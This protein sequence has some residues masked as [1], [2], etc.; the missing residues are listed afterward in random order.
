MQAI[1]PAMF[2]YRR[3]LAGMAAAMTKTRPSTGT[4]LKALLTTSG[5][6]QPVVQGI[7]GPEAVS[8]RRW[9]RRFAIS[10]NPLRACDGNRLQSSKRGITGDTTKTTRLWN[11]RR[12]RGRQSSGFERT[13]ARL[14]RGIGERQAA[15]M[16][17]E[18]LE[19][20][21]CRAWNAGCPVA[22]SSEGDWTKV[23]SVARRRWFSF[24]GQT[25]TGPIMRF[26]V[27]GPGHATLI[28]APTHTPFCEPKRRSRRI[29]SWPH[30]GK[31]FPTPP[32]S[33]VG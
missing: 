25:G 13:K 2:A 26:L 16:A 5:T 30:S 29:G 12:R 19:A 7:S 18:S 27:A 3:H 28:P 11:Q 20:H 31:P 14:P 15:S 22:G 4:T 17:I 32:P 6:A 8:F 33:A 9:N 24:E 23:A 10:R 1:C 21:L